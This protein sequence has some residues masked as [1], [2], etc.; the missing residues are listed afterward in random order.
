[1]KAI[2]HI[3]LDK[4]GTTSIQQFMFMNADY[5]YQK[6]GFLYP[7]EGL[8]SGHHV[9]IAQYLGFG[10]F[11][12]ANERELGQALERF[13]D[14]QRDTNI[15]LSSEHF[16][17]LRTP[18]AINNLREFLKNFE[19]TIVVYLRNQPEWLRSVYS[20]VIKWGYPGSFE[21]YFDRASYRCDFYGFISEWSSVFGKE[22]ILVKWF[23]REQEHLLRSFLK[24]ISFDYDESDTYL[25]KSL[26][27]E[28]L[29]TIRAINTLAAKLPSEQ[30]A[31][32]SAWVMNNMDQVLE[33]HMTSTPAR[34]QYSAQ[35]KCK[36]LE[37]IQNNAFIAEIAIADPPFLT[38]EESLSSM[39]NNCRIPND[40]SPHKNAYYLIDLWRQSIQNI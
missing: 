31:S 2:V 39:D 37:D 32:L 9:S 14:Y 35:H 4:T 13:T 36:L 16:C 27:M 15:I 34:W 7:P 22:K 24:I 33:Q 1:M 10:N 19:V 18:D 26:S 3:G 8:C 6:S 20:E 28:V 30:A 11:A 23:E 38:Y 5:I 21:E 12:P 29:E 17:Y 40:F 25:N